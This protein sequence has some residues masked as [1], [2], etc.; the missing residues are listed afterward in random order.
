MEYSQIYLQDLAENVTEYRKLLQGLEGKAILITGATGL[1]GSA[2]VDLLCYAKEELQIDMRVYAAGRSIVKL[3]N[4]FSYWKQLSFVLYEAVEPLQGDC[5]YDFVVHCASNAHPVAYNR[6]PVETMLTN[7]MGMHYL[8]EYVRHQ[9]RGARVL[10]VSSSEVYGNRGKEDTSWYT[11]DNYFDVDIL[12]PRACY[13]SGKRAAETLCAS[14]IGEY[15]LDIVIA[16]PGHIY[17][18][19]MTGTDSRASAQFFRDVLEKRDIVMKSQGVQLRSYCYML[20]CVTALMVVL[21]K[22]DCGKAYNI[23]NKESVVTI[24]QFAEE[25]A[26]QAG[27]HIIFE[28]PTEQEKRGYNLMRVSALD[29][30]R[31]EALGWQGRYSLGKGVRMTLNVMAGGTF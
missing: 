4:R 25:V 21:L 28:L 23:S 18:P 16:R 31:L 19:T 2:V 22:G 13:P 5:Q 14:Y 12:N 17:G 10:Y 20:D 24:R 11:E 26:R 7:F 9:D 6:M 27:Q 1:I 15:G 3:Q 8:L 29:A 30:A